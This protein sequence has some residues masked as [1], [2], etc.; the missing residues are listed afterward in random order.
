MAS[1]P[2]INP[3]HALEGIPVGIMSGGQLIGEPAFGIIANIEASIL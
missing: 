2:F 3:C 1:V